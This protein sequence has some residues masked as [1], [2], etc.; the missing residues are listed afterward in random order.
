MGRKKP[1]F[2]V[3]WK[4]RKTGVFTTW[5]DCSNQ[6]TTFEGAKFKSFES[7]NQAELAFN[8][9]SSVFIGQNQQKPTSLSADQI[10]LIGK[11][12]LESIS[13]DGAW[14]TKTGVVEYQG[15]HTTNKKVLFKMGPYQDGTINIVE[16]LAIVHA[17][18]YCK[19]Q[20]LS[21]PIYSDSRTAIAWLRRKEAK[22]NHP[23]SERNND[24][25]VL[26][27]KAILWL[28]NNDYSNKVLKWE[29]EAWGE[30]PADFD[31]K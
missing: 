22:T 1:K 30:N 9:A 28:N 23:R 24:L 18:A 10:T 4:G 17:L 25:F 21:L 29:T 31:R 13:V 15:V 14:N 26:I 19:K 27:D 3:V 2:Y 5:E 11:P 20:D 7:M 8:S 6:V 16:F 12:I